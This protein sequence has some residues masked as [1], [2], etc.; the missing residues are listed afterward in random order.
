MFEEERRRTDA[1]ARGLEEGGLEAAQEAER[2]EIALIRQ[3]KDEADE[4]NFRAFEAMMIEGKAIRKK[5]EEEA[6]GAASQENNPI[7][8][9]SG[10]TIVHVPE[11]AALAEQR[12]AQWMKPIQ[13]L[14]SSTTASALVAPP[15][16]PPV[17]EEIWSE[18]LPVVSEVVEES[19]TSTSG[20]TKCAIEEEVEEEQEEETNITEPTESSRGKFASLLEE[21]QAEVAR[22]VKPTAIATETDV[23]ALD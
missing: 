11:S 22:E 19:V 10:E 3:E 2:R 14:H 6:A 8:T 18:E 4:R 5:R 17:T 7:N 23:Y 1:W 16:P 21:A 9:F 15:P 12:A 20:W 13:N